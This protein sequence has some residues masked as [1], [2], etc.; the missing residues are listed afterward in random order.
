MNGR[1]IL[2]L[3]APLLI[4]VTAVMLSDRIMYL[5]GSIPAC[6]FYT[7]LGK[8]CPACGNTRSVIAL[9]HGDVL[10]ALRYNAA[11][12][13]LCLLGIA[14]YAERAMGLFG[15][16]VRIVPRGNRFIFTVIALSIVYFVGRNFVR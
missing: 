12:V 6:P 8:Y 2:F 9:L 7:L 16:K 15:K 13:F 4:A 10:G 3:S 1:K 5:A 11:M 14:L